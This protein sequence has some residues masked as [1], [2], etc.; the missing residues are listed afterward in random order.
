MCVCVCVRGRER[1][2]EREKGNGVD[3]NELGDSLW[4][5]M[6]SEGNYQFHGSLVFRI[7]KIQKDGQIGR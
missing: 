3:A 6:G 5:L 1:E 2:R 4:Y 7:F